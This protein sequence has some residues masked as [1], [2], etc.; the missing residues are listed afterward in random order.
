MAG[1]PTS[2]DTTLLAI[3]LGTTAIKVALFDVEGRLL[4][5]ANH[6]YELLTPSDAIVELPA[7][8]YWEATARGIRHVLAESG[9]AAER[10]AS[11][12]I[13][14][15]GETFVPM[16]ADGRELRNAIVW[17]DTRAA[18]WT[19]TLASAVPLDVYHCITGLNDVS[20]MF[21]AA[22]LLW[23]K[24][25]EED[26]FAAAA[27]YPLVHDYIIHKLAGAYVTVGAVSCTTGLYDLRTDEW[28]ADMLALV[29]IRPE[30]L[31][32]LRRPGHAAGRVTAD[33]A[34]ATGLAEGTLVCTGAMDQMAAAVGAG[35]VAPGAI[36]ASIGTALAIVATCDTAV[37]DPRRRMFTGPSAVAGKF[38]LVPYAQTAGMALKWFRDVFGGGDYD[39]M[40]A[41]AAQAPPGCDG[42]VMLPHLTGSTCPDPNP[43]ARG[44]FVGMS[45]SHER[46]HFVR[47]VMESVAFMLREIVDM[48]DDL[49]IP[50]TE[51]RA[52]GGG[53][54]S[55]FWLQMMADV[56]GR[57]VVVMEC[58]E[59]ACLGAAILAGVGAGIYGS[60]AS[61]AAAAAKVGRRYEPQ[62]PD[63]YPA[64]YQ[65]YCDAYRRLYR[66]T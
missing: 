25:H 9:V 4:C 42:L 17:L 38:V 55:P 47:A 45:M 40:A 58:T 26:V 6:E 57:P 15:Q 64:A 12:G 43:A 10:I 56:L 23:L 19:E 2:C 36:T 34:D 8:T 53:A 7:T 46:R 31:S 54:K 13:S 48:L 28:W 30:H 63:A 18:Q 24:A 27:K 51:V 16:S 32:E 5:L 22:K 66:M 52:M 59:A 1:A 14:S 21:M 11:V 44:A 29:G 61:G 62:S 60:I 39:A 33:A 49:G 41:A 35:N 65:A 50:T 3:D 20:P 37:L